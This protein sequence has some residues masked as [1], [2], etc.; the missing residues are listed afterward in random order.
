MWISRLS[1][2]RSADLPLDVF[3]LVYKT[4]NYVLRM[5]KKK[6]GKND[7]KI[8]QTAE[9]AILSFS[10]PIFKVEVDLPIGLT[11]RSP[12]RRSVL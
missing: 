12:E 10:Q 1:D 6:L 5:T 8:K 4:W 2:I 9:L 3:Y 11:N 7:R